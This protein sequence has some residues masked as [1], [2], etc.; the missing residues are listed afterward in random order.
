M[1]VVNRPHGGRTR[2]W[3]G[4]V[5]ARPRLTLLLVLLFTALAVVAGSG[6]ADRLGS[7]G[8][9]DPAAESA[10]ATKALEKHFPASQ[11]NLLLLV[12]SGKATVDAPAVAAEGRALAR[13]L[14]GEESVTGVT[15]YW[16]GVAALRD[17]DGREALIAARI[18][19]DE[20][21]AAKVLDRIAPAYR[22]DHGPVKVTI[23]GPVAVRHEL[24]TTIQED[25]LRAEMIALPITL[26]LLVMV[27]G[28]AIAALLPLGVGIIAI[29]G[30]DAVLRGLTEFTDVSVFAQNLTTALGLGLAIDY[31]LFIVRRFREE[32]GHGAETLPAIATTLRTAGRTVL[33]SALTVAVSLAAMLVFPQYFLRSFAYAGIAVVVIA[34]AAALVVLPAALAL[35]GERVNALDLTRLFRRRRPDRGEPGAG[36]ARLARL[37]MRRAP[38]FALATAA[39]LVVLG[40]PFLRVEF[41][42]AD[43]RQLPASAESHVVQ[44]H[45]RENFPGSPG[46]AIDIL[47]ESRPGARPEQADLADYSG[48]ISALPGVERVDSPAGQ[49]AGGRR[50]AEPGPVEAARAADGAAYVTV[51]S[52]GEIVDR[53]SQRLVRDIRAQHPPFTASVTGIAAVLVDSKDSIADRLPWALAIIVVVTLLLVFLLTGSVLIPLQA[54]LLNALSLTAMFGAVVWVFQEGHLSGPLSFTS[55]GDIET[56]LP[57]LMF[58]VAFGLSMD[59][60]V[61]L[62][63]RIKEEYDRTGD[64]RAAVEFGV[65]RTGGLI[66][67]AAVILAVVMVAIGTS[68]V[69]NTKMLGLGIAL[70]VLMDA[71]VVRSLLVPAVMRLTGR[72][73]WWAPG[74][75]RRL[76]ARI[77]LSEG[78]SAGPATGAAP[79]E[80]V[81]GAEPRAERVTIP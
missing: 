41:G 47:I 44:Q 55:T 79:V 21:A 40:L 51:L 57:V 60:G 48:R 2:G 78:E 59:Y 74:P 72:A 8:W 9:Q 70:A 38:L 13:K 26:L 71:M 69:T 58:C 61:F 64:H 75:L 28:S 25:L 1:T 36:W 34:A 17:R 43:D 45:I 22:G 29:L 20:S 80:E 10:Y 19:G 73:T 50:V 37:V 54:V 32:L 56:T 14:A 76:H 49:F 33:F 11:P 27:F 77:G 31:A 23:G 35:L 81:G 12:D 63:S 30:T 39:G 65:R 52:K 53:T 46:G 7:G 67:A 5:T 15:S 68:R 6:V 4:V 24:Q 66:T 62:L 16:D 3:T 42:T 18:V